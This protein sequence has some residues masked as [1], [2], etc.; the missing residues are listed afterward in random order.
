[1]SASTSAKGS[2]TQGDSQATSF[3][4]PGAQPDLAEIQAQQLA[5]AG[6]IADL[7]TKFESLSAG[8]NAMD[9]KMDARMNAMDA[10]FE[11]ILA[12]LDRA[13][14]T[15]PT[16]AV[17][18]AA[19]KAAA[20]KAE[21]AKREKEAQ[22]IDK[23][24]KRL[25]QLARERRAGNSPKADPAV[26]RDPQPPE[27]EHRALPTELNRDQHGPELSLAAQA[28]QAQDAHAQTLARPAKQAAQEQA[29]Q[30]QTAQDQAQQDQAPSSTLD[31]TNTD[32][33]LHT[34]STPTKNKASFQHVFEN[35]CSSFFTTTALNAAS[36]LS[37][38]L[39]ESTTLKRLRRSTPLH[40]R[41]HCHNGVY[42]CFHEAGD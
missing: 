21:E 5:Q 7:N 23:E 36:Q 42:R 3:N 18:A 10:K 22:E 33:F 16:S 24:V 9:T 13:P 20:E 14:E 4:A 30:D 31:P 1:M 29:A 27:A 37:S 12:R 41:L 11:A 34:S 15:R 8:M 26:H 25:Q 2:P 19:A 35:C 39:Q 28:T 6:S 38:A 17:D 32:E 40:E